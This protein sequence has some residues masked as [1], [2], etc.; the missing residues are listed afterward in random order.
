MDKN[1]GEKTPDVKMDKELGKEFEKESLHLQVKPKRNIS[2]Y[3][4]IAIIIIA[5]ILTGYF[6]SGQKTGSGKLKIVGSKKVVGSLDT[7]TFPDTATGV[8]EKGGIDGEGTHKLI[9]EGG[10]SQTVYL[11]SS[12]INLGDFVGKKVKVWGETQAAQKAGWF[13][14]VGRVEVNE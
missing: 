3:L 14:D 9:R 13:M 11:T 6:L 5:G 7:K 1:L 2:L 4:G 10:D 12:V 8:L